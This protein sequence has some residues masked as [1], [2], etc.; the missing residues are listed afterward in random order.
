M[1]VL[2]K[3]EREFTRQTATFS[4]YYDNVKESFLKKD[5]NRLKNKTDIV[6]SFYMNGI[7]VF[8]AFKQIRM[9]LKKK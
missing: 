2:T 3:E 9:V 1:K 8:E 5:W 7:S 6:Y 4:V